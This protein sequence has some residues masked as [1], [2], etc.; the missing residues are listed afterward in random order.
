ML[1]QAAPKCVVLTQVILYGFLLTIE[2]GSG[3]QH[4]KVLAVTCWTVT[5]GVAREI[6]AHHLPKTLHA[7]NELRF[8]WQHRVVKVACH[9]ADGINQR[10][11]VRV[12]II[13]IYITV[14]HYL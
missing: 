6:V 5:N 10:R 4:Q 12:L 7:D 1:P 3:L 13:Q 2:R 14:A 8:V 9:A 11:V